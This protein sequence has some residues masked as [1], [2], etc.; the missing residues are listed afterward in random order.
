[1]RFE[2]EH[3]VQGE[4]PPVPNNRWV[5]IALVLLATLMHTDLLA[6]DFFVVKNRLNQWKYGL[7]SA[8]EKMAVVYV[9]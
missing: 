9:Y 2:T 8:L 4:A 3:R 1:M 5:L 6:G 7:T